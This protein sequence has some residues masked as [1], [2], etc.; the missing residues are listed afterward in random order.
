MLSTGVDEGS[1]GFHCTKNL[2]DER[3]GR[4]Y[5]HLDAFSADRGEHSVQMQAG[6]GEKTVGVRSIVDF[7]C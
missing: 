7:E 5:S 4:R 1:G 3:R 2:G 6:R